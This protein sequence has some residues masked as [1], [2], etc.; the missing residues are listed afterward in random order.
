M[1]TITLVFPYEG[2]PYGIFTPDDDSAGQ[3]LDWI[4]RVYPEWANLLEKATQAVIEN[5]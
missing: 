5:D 4:R 1:P 3:V 2:A